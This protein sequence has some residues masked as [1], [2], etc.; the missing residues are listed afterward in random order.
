MF[1]KLFRFPYFVA[2][3]MSILKHVFCN[4]SEEIITQHIIR[5]LYPVLSSMH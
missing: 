3:V 5:K 4:E 1:L 2:H